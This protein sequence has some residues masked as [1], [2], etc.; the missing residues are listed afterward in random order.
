MIDCFKNTQN[1]KEED[2][3]ILWLIIKEEIEHK[4]CLQKDLQ[5]KNRFAKGKD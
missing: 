3:E 5:N 2:T 4:K 1:S